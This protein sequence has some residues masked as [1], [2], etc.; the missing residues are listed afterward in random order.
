MGTPYQVGVI[1]KKNSHIQAAGRP[2]NALATHV[3]D[4]EPL[5]DLCLLHLLL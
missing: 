3:A 4:G 2:L 5:Q 1:G